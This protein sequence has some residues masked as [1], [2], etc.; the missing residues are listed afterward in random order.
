M[1]KFCLPLC[2]FVLIPVKMLGAEEKPLKI[3][4]NADDVRKYLKNGDSRCPGCGVVTNIRQ[5]APKGG[6]SSG[7]L[8]GE[9]RVDESGIGGDVQPVTIAGTG[10]SSRAARKAA[11]APEPLRWLV[12]VRYDDGSYAAFEQ[13]DQPVVQRG[14]RVQVIS[15]RVEQR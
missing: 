2:L 15:G 9:A 12:T 5:L 10:S 1:L 14:E 7:T 4:Q 3:P 8:S 11:K 6:V 13:D